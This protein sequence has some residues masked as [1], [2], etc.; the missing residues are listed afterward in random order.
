MSS[1][2]PFLVA[3]AVVFST[4]ML[5]VASL[6]MAATKSSS[7]MG[8]GAAMKPPKMAGAMAQMPKMTHMTSAQ[9]RAAADRAAATRSGAFWSPPSSSSP[10]AVTKSVT[11]AA[12]VGSPVTSYFGPYP[13]WA[14]SPQ[15][16][17]FVDTLP[18]LGADNAN[19]LG[20]YLPIAQKVTNPDGSPVFAGSDYYEIGLKDYKQQ[21][22]SDLPPTTLRGYVDLAPGSDDNPHYLGPLIIAKRGVP[23]RLKFTNQLPTSDKPGANLWL[24][25]DT[26][27]MGAGQGPSYPD[28][29]G[30]YTENRATIHLHGGA[31]PWISDG[32]PHQWI[33]PKGDPSPYQTGVSQTNVPDMPDPGQGSATFWYSNDQSARL[34]WYHDHTYGMTRLNVYAGEVSAYLLTDSTE[35]GLIDALTLPGKNDGVYRYGVPLII[36]DKTFVPTPA[37]L[38]G[39]DPTWDY[40]KW[41]KQG[42]LWFPHVY[43]TNQNP[44]DA[45]GANAMG[46][47]D[48]GPWFWPPVT[49]G[50]A[51]GPVPSATVTGA[52]DPGI[53]NPSMVPEAFMDTPVVNGTAYPTMPVERRAYRFRILNGCN[54]RTLNLSLFYVDPAHPT[55][56]KMV[57][58]APHVNDPSW[59]ASWPTDGRD[60]G[61]PDPTTAGPN[62]IQI[63]TEGGLLPA[64]VTIP[65]QPVNYNY[66]RRDIVVLNVAQHAL[67]LGPAERADIVVDFSQVPAGSKIILYNDA[68]APV[69]AFDSRLDYYT[70]DPDQRSSG[71]ADTTLEGYGPN[72]RTVM[73]FEAGA[74]AAAPAFNAAALDTAL[75][76]AF[77]A[78]QP[79]PIIPESAYSSAYP[80]MT[81]DTYSRIASTTL[82]YVAPNSATTVTVGLEP[83]AIQELFELNY[84]RMNATLG[85]ELPFTNFNTQTTIPLGYVD[86][87]TEIINNGDTQ[88]WKITHNGVD[89][90]S[91]HFH[92]FNVQLINRVGWDGA[93]RP[94]DPNEL[95]WK[96]TVRMNPLEDAI[97]AFRAVA[98]GNIPF[99]VP[100][101]V[102]PLDPTMPL[103]A[104]LTLTSPV[105]GNPVIGADA[106]NH[107]VNFGWEYIWH[108]HLL[109]H[110]ENDMMRTIKFNGNAPVVA[111]L[112]GG[113]GGA[114]PPVTK[115]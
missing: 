70:G 105:D 53:P 4:A 64:P 2:K 111:P 15:I 60:G 28:Y 58:A 54:D 57:P 84:G 110:E 41:G 104:P 37:Q 90:H 56:V 99:A 81:V 1:R 95:G 21:M 50:L 79:V 51:H 67:M 89:T 45:S 59:P 46:R 8:A 33:T 83:K 27:A 88:I 16:R 11:A 68:P 18:G 78:S 100:D 13:N 9:R 101:S 26:T 98:P 14:N 85:V 34:M 20:Q 91:I 23:V 17:K 36:Q 62:I 29:A 94:P 25:V 73:R 12:T 69:P 112:G 80:T 77:K 10:L 44:Q 24:P 38:A 55:E 40:A 19:N 48:Y 32:T 87:V 31:T 93:I 71:G 108:C 76:A 114:R 47:W 3:A 107:K 74:A 66:N 102:R 35:D 49:A 6:A 52:L 103:G 61:V 43:M 75:P 7:T 5:G 82:T 42:D 63:G 109:G 30:N 115:K 92:L 22:N 113:T 106:L 86:P 97:V 72:T 65:A 39:Q 96:E